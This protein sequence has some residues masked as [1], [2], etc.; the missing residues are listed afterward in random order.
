MNFKAMSREA[1]KYL[2]PAFLLRKTKS[3]LYQYRRVLKRTKKPNKEEFLDV[4][5]I[6][7]AGILAIGIIGFIIQVVFINII[8]V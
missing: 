8:Q 6:S 3:T 2:N 1:A 4:V 5:K 7:A